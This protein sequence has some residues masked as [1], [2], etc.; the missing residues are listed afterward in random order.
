MKRQ[1]RRRSA[2]KPPVELARRIGEIT[3]VVLQYHIDPPTRQ[4]MILSAIKALYKAAGEPVPP[5]L[6]RR[7]SV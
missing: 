6:G 4:Q 1:H 7:V 2:P 5:G 3:D